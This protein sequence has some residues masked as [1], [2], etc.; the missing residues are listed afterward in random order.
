M[1]CVFI[2]WQGDDVK[3]P[4]YFSDLGPRYVKDIKIY[5]TANLADMTPD[6]VVVVLDG[7]ILND[8]VQLVADEVYVLFYKDNVI[9]E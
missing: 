2:R 1:P 8:D 7:I 9:K 5:Y 4:L 3:R 6:H